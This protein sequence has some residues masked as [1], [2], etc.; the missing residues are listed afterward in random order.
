[1]DD[2][3]STKQTSVMPSEVNEDS[4]AIAAP[5]KI[6]VQPLSDTEKTKKVLNNL[7]LH[8]ACKLKFRSK[9]YLSKILQVRNPADII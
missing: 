1:M 8:V 7:I 2:G 9:A 4:T 5:R 3:T 6:K